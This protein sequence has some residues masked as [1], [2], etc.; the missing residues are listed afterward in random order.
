VRSVTAHSFSLRASLTGPL[1]RDVSYQREELELAV[2]QLRLRS[3]DDPWLI[4]VRLDDCEIPDRDI[5]G[6]RTLTSIQR[7]DLFGSRR[8]EGTV[9]LVT[10]ILQILGRY[11]TSQ[12]GVRP[13]ATPTDVLEWEDDA[14]KIMKLIGV[15][16][17]VWLWGAALTEHIPI[18]AETLSLGVGRGLRARVL[19][20]APDSAS[21]RMLAFRAVKP[22]S[23]LSETSYATDYIHRLNETAGILNR[24]LRANIEDLERIAQ[25]SPR[26]SLQYRTIDYL[27]PYV[28]YAFDPASSRGKLIVR[29]GFHSGNNQERPTLWFDKEKD[30]AWFAHFMHQLETAW[31]AAS[32]I[33]EAGGWSASWKND[34]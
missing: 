31:S 23:S 3:P 30:P 4:P 14:K 32:A 27:A 2:E 19:L 34:H 7:A 28:I 17:E 22:V 10:M 13:A 1:S 25:S 8:A 21:V 24:K 12:D 26:D 11:S 9:R 6:G 29:M 16:K 15:S 5:G 20:I 33:K 18:L